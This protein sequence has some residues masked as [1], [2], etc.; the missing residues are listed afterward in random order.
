M[1]IALW[2]V[3][4]ADFLESTDAIFLIANILFM[5]S[6]IY[7]I[8]YIWSLSRGLTKDADYQTKSWHLQRQQLFYF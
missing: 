6:L 3:E 2:F 5:G 1:V 8:T 4:G 7:L